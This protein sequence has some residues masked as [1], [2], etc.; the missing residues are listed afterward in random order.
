MHQPKLLLLDEPYQGF[1]W[2]AYLCFGILLP[3]R[4]RGCSV[5][6]STPVIEQAF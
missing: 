2:E 6:V 5:L 1:D 4:E 3:V